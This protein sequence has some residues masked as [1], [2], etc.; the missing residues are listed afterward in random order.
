M[1][2]HILFF[3]VLCVNLSCTKEA[4]AGDR[5]AA[6][7]GEQAPENGRQTYT[8]NTMAVVRTGAEPFW[9]ELA[10]G[11]PRL[12]P[13]LQHAALEP[14]V[15]WKL[16]R[17]IAAFLADES[18]LAAAVNQEGFLVFEF[19]KEGE[20]AF[21]YYADPLW[22]G[23]SV[24]S[25]FRFGNFPAALLARDKIFSD[26]LPPSPNP[27]LRYFD[28]TA[29]KGFEPAAFAAFSPEDGWETVDLLWDGGAWYCRK[30]RGDGSAGEEL[31]LK[32]ADLAGIS[33]RSSGA[34]FLRAA[35]PKDP[36]EAPPAAGIFLAAALE[37]AGA[38]AG[39][40]CTF[41]TVSPEFKAPVVFET[42]M[43]GD[44]TELVNASAY[45]RPG[46]A[47]ALLPD[48]RGVFRGASQ[49]GEFALPSLPEGYVYTA[50]CLAG[51][52]NGAYT[53][54]AAWEEQEAWNVGAAG[55]GMLEIG[56]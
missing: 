3:A 8:T 42:G 43:G 23:Y 54:I 9:F 40:P 32:A 11:G 55:F 33:E 5:G 18:R 14:F 7:A 45:C 21:Y 46:A 34:A 25:V 20:I 27:A 51:E 36:A 13:S 53:V 15:P 30:L 4:P 24:S 47:L 22:N 49:G 28:G 38:L 31:Y 52:N 39:K 12:I 41:N 56:F 44:I 35:R 37:A 6:S 1:K 17:Y 50:V 29:V 2:L 26:P 16:S 48:G 19:Q 10:A